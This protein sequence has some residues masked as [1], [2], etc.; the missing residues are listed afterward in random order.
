MAIGHQTSR[1]S[2]GIEPTDPGVHYCQAEGV[3]LEH[4]L[5]MGRGRSPLIAV[6]SQCFKAS[7]ELGMSYALTG[8]GWHPP[9]LWSRQG[10]PETMQETQL[11]LDFKTSRL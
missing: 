8:C 9:D 7:P 3:D 11:H 6:G 1:T 5:P 10:L 2:H 4:L